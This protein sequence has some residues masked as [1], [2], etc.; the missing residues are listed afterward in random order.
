MSDI[1]HR[2]DESES[3]IAAM[4]L[5]LGRLRADL[6]HMSSMAGRG[7]MMGGRVIETRTVA[8]QS[9]PASQSNGSVIYADCIN[10]HT[11]ARRWAS[12]AAPLS[13]NMA[14][15]YKSESDKPYLDWEAI[16]SNAWGAN[17][18][19]QP[20]NALQ[21]IYSQNALAPE[22][23]LLNAPVNTGVYFLS[24]DMASNTMEWILTSEVELTYCNGSGELETSTFWRKG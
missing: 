11:G 21:M 1:E 2:M 13:N 18:M 17:G 14:L 7:A 20:T 22:W 3:R 8:P 16:N 15:V 23:V 5:E 10:S 12:L 4:S 6:D 24:V 9:L 19:I